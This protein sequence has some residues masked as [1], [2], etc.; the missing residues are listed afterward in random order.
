[1]RVRRIM[2][3]RT[4]WNKANNEHFSAPRP[5]IDAANGA[6]TT[7]FQV[8]CN[9]FMQ[10]NL[11]QFTGIPLEMNKWCCSTAIKMQMCCIEVVFKFSAVFFDPFTLHFPA[12]NWSQRRYP[13][14]PNN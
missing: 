13:G 10:P 6:D 2:A 14:V 5:M 1:M 9:V 7:R 4:G 8:N 11:F 3:E 12:G